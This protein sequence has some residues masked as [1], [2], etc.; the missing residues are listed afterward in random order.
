MQWG[1]GGTLAMFT[2]HSSSVAKVVTDEAVV[3]RS[4]ELQA[5]LESR[6]LSAYC[7]SK[8]AAATTPRDA[9]EWSL[10][11]VLCSHEQRML[12]LQFLG[13]S[14]EPPPPPSSPNAALPPPAAGAD[15]D[16]ATAS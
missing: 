16:P 14:E 1:F 5:A 12:L 9:A 10:M 7:A 13:L 4:Q 8:A 6:E 15:D 11:Q 3:A 2:E